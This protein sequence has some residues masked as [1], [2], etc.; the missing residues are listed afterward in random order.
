MS[1][2]TQ[3]KY[4]EK[5]VEVVRVDTLYQVKIKRDS[6]HLRDS[7]YLN[8]YTKG[9]TV[10]QNKYRE[11]VQYID[12]L[13]VDTVYK[14]KVDTIYKSVIEEKTVQKS[15]IWIFDLVKLIVA[16]FLMLSGVYLWMKR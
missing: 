14:S 16:I 7:V 2:C 15:G 5:T 6:V 10:Y 12:K 11:R 3:T 8:V 1:S 9:D 13:K 4:V